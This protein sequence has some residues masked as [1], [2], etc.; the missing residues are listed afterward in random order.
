MRDFASLSR[1][2]AALIYK[3][4]Q[5]ISDDHNPKPQKVMR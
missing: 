4:S 3:L 1:R 2:Q 5:T